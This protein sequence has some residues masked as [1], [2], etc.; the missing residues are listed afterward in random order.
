ME[1][2]GKRDSTVAWGD[3]SFSIPTRVGTTNPAGTIS[4]QQANKG[5][6]Q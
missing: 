3:I 2:A 4:S 6:E 5:V 1:D